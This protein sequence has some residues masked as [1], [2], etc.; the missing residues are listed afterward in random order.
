[1][2]VG[3]PLALMDVVLLWGPYVQLGRNKSFPSWSWAG[4]QGEVYW[5]HC[6]SDY[7]EFLLCHTWIESY[8]FSEKNNQFMPLRMIAS[9][10]MTSPTSM[11][12]HYQN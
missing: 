10:S 2:L 7:N 1:M 3:L 5:S 11:S 12:H 9:G 4:W 6:K 8:H